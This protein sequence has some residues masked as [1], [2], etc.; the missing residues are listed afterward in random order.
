MR[1]R[2]IIKDAPLDGVG[3]GTNDRISHDVSSGASS[4]SICEVEENVNR[5]GQERAMHGNIKRV[6]NVQVNSLKISGSG[7]NSNSK[8]N[9]AQTDPTVKR[10]G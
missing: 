5:S 9:V 1:A 8:G 7:Q 2:H 6:G 3:R 4:I 10:K